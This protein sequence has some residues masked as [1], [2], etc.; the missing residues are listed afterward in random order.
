MASD[1]IF[2]TSATESDIPAIS[3]E[4]FDSWKYIKTQLSSYDEVVSNRWSRYK[5]AQRSKILGEIDPR[6]PQKHRPDII[7]FRNWYDPQKRA[8]PMQR[9]L[10]WPHITHDDL[11]LEPRPMLQFMQSRSTNRPGVFEYMDYRSA[12]VGTTEWLGDSAT[13]FTSFLTVDHDME[14]Y[15]HFPPNGDGFEYGKISDGQAARDF[16]QTASEGMLTL[17]IQRGIY[18]FLVR[19]CDLILRQKNDVE[20]I[21]TSDVKLIDYGQALSIDQLRSERPYLV[22]GKLDLD[23]I[24][25][26]VEVYAGQAESIVISMIENPGIFLSYVAEVNEHRLEWIRDERGHSHPLTEPSNSDGL[27]SLSVRQAVTMAMERFLRWSKLNNSLGE[28]VSLYKKY[29]GRRH[30]SKKDTDQLHRKLCEVWWLAEQLPVSIDFGV[31]VPGSTWLREYFTREGK[32]KHD[33]EYLKYGPSLYGFEPRDR[34]PRAFRAIQTLNDGFRDTQ[35]F[36]RLLFPGVTDEFS[37]F[38]ETDRESKDYLT[39]ILMDLL[40]E[41]FLLGDVQQE[42]E[43]VGSFVRSTYYRNFEERDEI[44]AE[45][46][47]EKAI[48]NDLRVLVGMASFSVAA[49]KRYHYPASRSPTVDIVKTLQSAEKALAEFWAAYEKQFVAAS[50]MPLEDLRVRSVILG[51]LAKANPIKI[52]DWTA[53]EQSNRRSKNLATASSEV[54][55]TFA[56]TQQDRPMRGLDFVPKED[57]KEKTNAD[58]KAEKKQGGAIAGAAGEQEQEQ[59]QEQENEQGDDN[60]EDQEG[61]EILPLPEMARN[62]EVDDNDDVHKIKLEPRDLEI[63]R[64]FFYDPNNPRPAGTTPWKSFL[65]LM[66]S[67]GFSHRPGQGSAVMFTPLNPLKPNNSTRRFQTHKPHGQGNTEIKDTKAKALGRRM[68][69]VYGWTMDTFVAR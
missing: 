1:E 52:P 60:E 62:Q 61:L 44:C 65:R 68:G 13:P 48:I 45:T 51:V 14:R 25:N 56:S 33:K 31:M 22:P 69:F 4:I 49:K 59:E 46:L 47:F 64:R 43:R 21:C 28:L 9:D 16:L 15:M 66:T 34:T 53:P 29:E 10:M 23:H 63:I 19:V 42:L 55:N 57:R 7:A 27:W 6:I 50:K 32:R 54:V 17:L 3:K 8:V 35:V 37:W 26:F 41:L 39:E 5:P 12:S 2:R 67:L 24:H 38:M 58:T 36:L 11:A 40:D 30:P 18:K 20:S